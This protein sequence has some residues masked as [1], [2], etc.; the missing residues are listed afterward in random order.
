MKFWLQWKFTQVPFA[1]L[2]E[3]TGEAVLIEGNRHG[4]DIWGCVWRNGG[5]SGKNHLGRLLTEVR[6]EARHSRISQQAVAD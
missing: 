1:D 4:D 3:A 2:L 5:W 6:S